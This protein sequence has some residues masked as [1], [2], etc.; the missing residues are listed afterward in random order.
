MKRWRLSA[1]RR[2]QNTC[3]ER[4]VPLSTWVLGFAGGQKRALCPRVATAI[5]GLGHK[6][7]S[8]ETSRR[9]VGR[10]P[11]LPGVGQTEKGA[12]RPGQ[13]ATARTD[14]TRE[15]GDLLRRGAALVEAVR[16]LRGQPRERQKR[17][18][19]HVDA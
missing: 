5:G 4:F 2:R 1:S 8:A 7:T 9:Q 13:V 18:R 14:P 19:H 16:G 3:R 11:R 17:W 15:T 10:Q 12:G 6:K